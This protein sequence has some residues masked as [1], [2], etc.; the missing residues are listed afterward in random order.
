[1]NTTH[2]G[3]VLVLASLVAA[4]APAEALY[5]MTPL[6]ATADKPHANVG[7][8]IVVTIVPEPENETAARDWAGQT[9]R[10]HYGYDTMEGAEGLEEPPAGETHQ[11][12]LITDALTLDE[13]ARGEFRWTVPAEVDD[14]NVALQVTAADGTLLAMANIAV[15]DAPPMLMA[16][17]GAPDA[18]AEEGTPR[19]GAG[20]PIR[21]D[22]VEDEAQDD[23]RSDVPALG[24]LAGLAVLAVVA[25]VAARRR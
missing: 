1:M 6:H 19:E 8:D 11:R 14:R 9:V 15:G 13:G 4:A 12:I 7:D 23:A 16:A 20:E 3:L 21:S 17:T 25:L 18:G 10:V 22:V 2:A 5:I 24:A